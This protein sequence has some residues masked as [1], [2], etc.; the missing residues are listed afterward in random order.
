LPH[1]PGFVAAESDDLTS[2]PGAGS[3]YSTT[4]D[5][6]RW[7]WALHNGRALNQSSLK[8][9]T[10]P[11]LDG[12]AYGLE[13]DDGKWIGHNGVIDGFCVA[14]DYLPKTKTIVLIFSN[15]SS[16][17]NQCSPGSFAMETELM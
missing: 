14:V 3:L 7:T 10:A 13:V 1:S 17:G 4:G 16:D 9:I 8:E 5:L 11:F 2:I 6:I 12:Y 15:V